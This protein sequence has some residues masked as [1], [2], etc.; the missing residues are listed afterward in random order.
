MQLVTE[1]P[2]APSADAMANQAMQM[3]TPEAQEALQTQVDSM[4]DEQKQQAVEDA[5]TTAEDA[6]RQQGLSDEM[7]QQV[8]E[9]AEA[10]ARQMFD[11]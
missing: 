6:A 10:A 5:R 7:I 8:G 4:T 9:Q 2:A 3:L 1:A 11:L